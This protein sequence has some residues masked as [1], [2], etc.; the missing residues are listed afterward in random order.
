MSNDVVNTISG[1]MAVMPQKASMLQVRLDHKTYPRLGTYDYQ[2][3]LD[4]L[5]GIILLCFQYRG[6]QADADNVAFIATELLN[7]LLED[8]E[9]IGT[10][11]LTFEEI[12]RLFRQAI[13]GGREMYGISVAS[14]YPILAD[15]CNGEGA[16][17]HQEELKQL[18]AAQEK[19]V[20][21]AKADMM[22]MLQAY[23]GAMMR[24]KR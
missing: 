15:Y 22:P 7:Y 2:S 23:A 9:K 19:K 21:Q 18:R 11:N 14:L 4:S 1:Q 12:G 5:T 13:M 8:P 3:A 16:K 6:Q 17:L 10:R 20:E 24:K